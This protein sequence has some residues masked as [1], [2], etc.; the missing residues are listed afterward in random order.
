MTLAPG[1]AFQR[2]QDGNE[3]F[4][5]GLRSVH[6]F[7]TEELRMKLAEKG[8]KPF[9]MILS[10][11]DAR[12]PAE[13][14]FDCGLGD[15]FVVRVAGNVIAPSLIGSL[16]FAAEKF[17]TPLCLVLGHTDCGAI[18]ATFEQVTQSKHPNS[19]HVRVIT[20]SIIPAVKEVC[21]SEEAMT[22]DDLLHRITVQ[23]IR[24]SVEK[25]IEQSSIIRHRIA[26]QKIAV[27][28]AVYSLHDGR[29]TF[30]ETDGYKEEVRTILKQ[31]AVQ[32][33]DVRLQ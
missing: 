21:S 4:I 10:C 5:A 22:Q 6:S 28:G 25:I 32:P 26:E 15:L 19:E 29:V 1:K 23:N 8:Q 16:E 12:V 9:A 7:A 17:E 24:Q 30:L 2:L 11:S 3:R 31:S 27:V 14:V 20:E 13:L 18:R 33:K